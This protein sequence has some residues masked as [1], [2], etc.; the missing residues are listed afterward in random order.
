MTVGPDTNGKSGWAAIQSHLDRHYGATE[1]LHWG[2]MIGF[3]V[4]GPDPLD[5]ISAYPIKPASG[6]S[7][8][9]YVSFGMCELYEKESDILEQSGWGYEFTMRLR[10]ED[11]GDPLWVCVLL[12]QL[13]RYVYRTGNTFASNEHVDFQRPLTDAFETDMS[14]LIIVE[15][16]LL[17]SIETPNGGL[18][19]LQLFAIT[20]DEVEAVRSWNLEKMVSLF[21]SDNPLLI[22]DM[23][24]PSIMTDPQYRQAIRSG[25]QKDGSSCG[26]Y[27]FTDMSWEN[28]SNLRT[29]ALTAKEAQAFQGLLAGRTLQGREAS[30]DGGGGQID[31]LP[32]D[33]SCFEANG[34]ENHFVLRLSQEAAKNMINVLG[35]KGQSVSL[36]DVPNLLIY[37]KK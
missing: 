6:S 15:D 19:F 2:T 13:A 5:G 37:I 28:G 25:V 3:R 8:W 4:G 1:P 9:H 27:Y 14:A 36:P 30:I 31:V 33:T 7:Y 24:R 10:A 34:A 12:Q 29:L 26:F 23:K 18:Q 20:A 16:P 22:S 35:Q 11:L 17:G 32:S 21:R